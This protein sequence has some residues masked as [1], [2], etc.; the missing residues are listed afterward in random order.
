MQFRVRA[1]HWF[2][3]FGVSMASA[4][5][6]ALV[7]EAGNP[8]TPTFTLPIATPT[9]SVTTTVVST[10]TATST[11]PSTPTATATPSATLNH[12]QCYEIVRQILE[13]PINV[14]LVDRFAAFGVQL[15]RPMRLCNPADKNDEDP[16]A[17]TDPD[18]LIGYKVKSVVPRATRIANVVVGNQFGT[19]V[20]DLVKPDWLFVPSSKSLTFPPPAPNEGVDHFLCYKIA[21]FAKTRLSGIVV[22]DQFGTLTLDIKRPTRICVPANKNGEGILDTAAN[23]AC[24]EVRKNPRLPR[25]VGPAPIFVDTQF[26]RPTQIEITRPTELCVPSVV[27]LGCCGPTDRCIEA[28]GTATPG[29]GIPLAVGVAPG[30][31]LAPFPVDA[32]NGSGL[33]M[34]DND[35]DADWTFGFNGDDLH[36]DGTTFCPTAISDGVHNAGADC[37][38]LDLNGSLTDGQAESCDLETGAGCAAPLPAPIK[39]HDAN[40]NNAWDNGEDIVLDVNNDGVCN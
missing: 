9:P 27:S 32:P 24:Y 20:G 2:V 5:S 12:F 34:F 30:A 35:L 37:V 15:A 22:D 28:D 38:V 31:A 13:P 11:A 21:R 17:P 36:V 8:P 23:L 18:H 1:T 3:R 16:T 19:I 29:H 33:A 40:G 39:Y 26:D 7:S 14:S 10:A 6:L 4:V 25:F